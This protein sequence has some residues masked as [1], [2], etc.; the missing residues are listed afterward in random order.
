[1]S[2]EYQ[3]A[4][5]TWNGPETPSWR[6]AMNQLTQAVVPSS[7]LFIVFNNTVAT[8]VF[9]YGVANGSDLPGGIFDRINWKGNGWTVALATPTRDS[10]YE[11]LQTSIRTGENFYY[12]LRYAEQLKTVVTG[13]V[14]S[15][16]SGDVG[17]TGT[18]DVAGNVNSTIVG[19]VDIASAHPLTVIQG[20][21]PWLVSPSAG[22]FLVRPDPG[23]VFTVEPGA[24]HFLVYPGAGADFNV[25]LT[26]NLVTVR[27]TTATPLYITSPNDNPPDV[28]IVGYRNQPGAM[29]ENVH[30]QTVGSEKYPIIGTSEYAIL[31]ASRNVVNVGFQDPSGTTHAYPIVLDR[32]DGIVYPA[33]GNACFG[34]LLTATGGDPVGM[35]HVK[36]CTLPGYRA[37]QGD[38]T[39]S[40]YVPPQLSIIGGM[41]EVLTN[42]PGT[43]PLVGLSRHLHGHL[44]APTGDWILTT[45]PAM[46]TAGEV[47]RRDEN[48]ETNLSS[49]LALLNPSPVQYQQVY[50]P[51]SGHTPQPYQGWFG[52]WGSR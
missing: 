40:Y 29:V 27:N 17:I 25:T 38:D 51:R 1:M 33:V 9:P 31:P 12:Y 35:T 5:I 41:Y 23:S 10:G 13:D 37:F 32:A 3:R 15:T 21:D 14:S 36:L 49:E 28:R 45:T 42:V 18:V 11:A 8:A 22:H 50:D 19:T 7:A 30:F 44:D 43:I 4:T 24:G 48:S 2:V 52:R 6:I 39:T 34:N 16:I 47:Q 26:S 46:R 20:P